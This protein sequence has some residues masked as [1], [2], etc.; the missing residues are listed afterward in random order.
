MCTQTPIDPDPPIPAVMYLSRLHDTL[1]RTKDSIAEAAV[2]VGRDPSEVTLV[3]VSKGH[4]LEAVQAAVAAGL[5]D[6]GENRVAEL[7]WKSGEMTG[8]GIRWHMVGQLQS[9][10]A[11]RLVGVTHLIHSVDRPSVAQ[12]LGRAAQEA[13]EVVSILVQVNTSGEE[14]KGG[15]AW[16]GAGEEVL[17]LSEIPGV[18]VEGLMTMAP[19]GAEEPVLRLTFRRLRELSQAVRGTGGSVG[20]HLSMGMSNDLAVAVEEGSTM[21][22]VGT[23]LFGPRPGGG[24]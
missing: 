12:R 2:R 21:V 14:A 15:V 5:T 11:P 16:D 6:L 1:P 13:G 7:E 23:A 19:F 8:E 4:P 3:A 24:A 9:R 20:G 17:R 10:K 22:R 18:R